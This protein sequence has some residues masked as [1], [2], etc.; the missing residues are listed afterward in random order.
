MASA[1]R[2]PRTTAILFAVVLLALIVGAAASLIASASSPTAFQPT[3]NRPLELTD[4]QYA[5]LFGIV[6]VVLLGLAIATLVRSPRSPLPGRFAVMMFMI[7][8]IAVLFLVVF[9]AIAPVGPGPVT[10]SPGNN[11]TVNNT[12]MTNTTLPGDLPGSPGSISGP[13]GLHLPSWWL[14]VAVAVVVLI[15]A[16][17]AV[18]AWRG[19]ESSGAG[20]RGQSP[21]GVELAEVRGALATA[22]W[23]LTE[24]LSPRDVVIRLYGNLLDRVEPIVGGVAEETPEEIRVRHLVRLGI[25]EAEAT[26]LTRL[27]EEARYSTHPMGADAAERAGAAIRAAEEDLGARGSTA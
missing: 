2:P 6:G 16:A 26:A 24:G 19:R 11:T 1:N 25:R 13:L 21:P 8:L 5:T 9:R 14:Y 10:L 4:L 27:F 18:P 7:I 12:T 17:V 23:E 20:R 15:V 3:G 22:A